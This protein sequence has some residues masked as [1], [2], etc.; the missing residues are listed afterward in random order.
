M[1]YQDSLAGL[2]SASTTTTTTSVRRGSDIP[3]RKAGF[4]PPP[5]TPS[6]TLTLAAAKSILHE[7]E[8][9]EGRGHVSAAT[10]TPLR[11]KVKGTEDEQSGGEVTETEEEDRDGKQE[12]VVVC[13]RCVA[14][15]S[16][17]SLLAGDLSSLSL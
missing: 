11:S 6:R 13:L 9:D 2:A 1:S 3:R 16:L 8:D 5:S 12:N 15:E 14:L 7:E 17:L 10:F 4:G